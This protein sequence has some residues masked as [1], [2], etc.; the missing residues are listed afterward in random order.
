MRHLAAVAV[1][2]AVLATAAMAQPKCPFEIGKTYRYQFVAQGQAIGTVTIKCEK[3]P[4]ALMKLVSRMEMGAGGAAQALDATLVVGPDL[5]P[6]HYDVKG[7]ARGRAYQY[8]CEYRKD[9]V[10]VKGIRGGLPMSTTVLLPE[11]W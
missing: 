2:A 6:T 1:C 5:R 10:E 4:G 11:G 9:R 3:E 8:T 7:Q